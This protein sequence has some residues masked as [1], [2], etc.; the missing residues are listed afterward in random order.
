MNS[1]LQ[2]EPH[3]HYHFVT[4]RLAEVAVTDVVSR[5]A[6]E[7]G[8]QYSIGVMPI[9]VAALMTPKW[10][11]RH[12]NVPDAATHVVL[13]G[14]CEV[15]LDELNSSLEIP[16]ICGPKD[17]RAMP[18]LFGKG[19]AK[20]DLDRY[21]ID[22]IAEINHAPR[23]TIEQVVRRAKKLR[24]D[25]ADVID[26]GCDPAAPC[27]NIGDYIAAL[28]DEGMRVSVD[29]FDAQEAKIATSR[30][31]S[32]VL[33]VNSSNRE[34]AV[35]WGTEVVVI[36]DTPEDEKSLKKNLSF[37]TDRGVQTRLD[38]IL[39][40]LGAGRGFLRS[41]M[42]YANTRR[43]FP[44]AKMMM[45]IGNLTELSDVDSAG[46]NFLLLGICQELGITSVLT[47]EVI[48]WAR[49]S[50]REC[51]LARRL[52]YHSV[53]N[54][55]P[56]KRL[57]DQL[58]LLR[59]DRLRTFSEAAIDSLASTLKDNNYRILA[60]DDQIHVLAA[61][62]HLT[63]DDPFAIFDELMKRDIADNVD[64]GHAFYLGFEMAKASIALLLG[65]QYEQDE[66]LR[67]G[68]LTKEEDHH[69]IQRTSRH[70]DRKSN[71]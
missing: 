42:R 49:S 2:P 1:H 55:V 31:A 32:L 27:S 61:G 68:F 52:T 71:G 24:E 16:V 56:P 43:E 13:P 62:L 63:G 58:I 65:K 17:C 46:V 51:D 22:I 69:R 28:I 10:L 18:E 29:T 37:L 36:P 8:F 57:S 47:T 59:D 7:I 23:L 48:N 40:P 21:D 64:P 54:Q 50:V 67:W 6:D 38:P 9:T 66:A 44:D 19:L 60:Q 14:Y 53:V 34:A 12:L 3:H 5:L 30:G 11:R 70:R 20:V 4:G 25:G 15:G 33:S 39:E 35:D 45:G 41:L 26:F